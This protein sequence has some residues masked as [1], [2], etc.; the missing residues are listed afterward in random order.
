MIEARFAKIDAGQELSQ[1]RIIFM[2]Y[3]MPEMTG[4][5]AAVIIFNKFEERGFNPTNVAECPLICCLSAYTDTPFI[6]KAK[7]VGINNYLSKPASFDTIL[8][9]MSKI[10]LVV[11]PEPEPD[12]SGAEN[13]DSEAGLI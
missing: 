11:W 9:I 6:E 3:S 2:D 1:Y 12:V 4:I 7:S 5:E 10:G 8:E 13:E